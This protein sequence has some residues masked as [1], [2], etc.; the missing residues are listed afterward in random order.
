ML[1]KRP[2]VIVCLSKHCKQT[3]YRLL[4]NCK[5]S[6]IP[7][8]SHNVQVPAKIAIQPQADAKLYGFRDFHLYIA[9]HQI[10]VEYTTW[11]HAKRVIVA[12]IAGIDYEKGK[13]SLLTHTV[14]C[15]MLLDLSY[16]NI[17]YSKQHLLQILANGSILVPRFVPL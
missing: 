16:Y 9:Q 12:C 6:D 2:A 1:L 14:A 10:M 7:K 15:I 17:C 4:T 8:Q 3:K 5:P 11:H 13:A